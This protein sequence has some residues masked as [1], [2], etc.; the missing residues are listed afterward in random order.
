MS[1]KNK[2]IV[3]GLALGADADPE[4]CQA[5]NFDISWIFQYPSTLI[6]AD[7]IVVTP[8]IL[9][10]FK[11]PTWPHE[12]KC[13]NGYPVAEVKKIFFDKAGEAGLIEVRDPTRDIDDSVRDAL[14]NHVE[15]DRK[16]LAEMFPSAVSLDVEENVP[17]SMR[18]EGM[19]YCTPRI[20]SIY[21]SLLLADRWGAQPLLNDHTYTYLKYSFGIRASEL[22]ET[23]QRLETFSQLFREQLPEIDI[24]PHTEGESCWS[25]AQFDTCDK[26]EHKEIQKRLTDYLRLREYDEVA[27][28][29]ALHSELARKLKREQSADFSGDIK[30][31][32]E[33]TRRI[34]HRRFNRLF[35]IAMRWSN[36]TTILSIPVVVAGVTTQSPILAGVG[37][38][39]AGLSQI[40]RHYMEILASKNRWLCFRQDCGETQRKT[41]PEAQ[42]RPERD[43]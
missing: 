2:I 10:S 29:K 33:D 15:K 12:P 11:D 7:S 31:R 25:C 17:G 20:L 9:K 40:A 14:R 34:L 5:C 38:G 35:P 8:T 42:Q 30:H 36:L 21:Y 23:T 1:E 27:Q 22:Q 19:H 4:T 13:P 16:I 6:W 41:E 43:K 32:F 24:R 18:I 39:V 26:V 3:T 28:M 37:A